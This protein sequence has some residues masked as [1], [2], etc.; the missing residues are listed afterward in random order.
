MQQNRAIR[1]GFTLAKH[2]RLKSR[3][4]LE[5]LFRQAPTFFVYPYK[6]YY[7]QDAGAQA[8]P[9]QAAF[10]VSARTFKK[11]ADRNRIKRLTREVYRLQKNPLQQKL[12]STGKKLAVFFLYTGKEVPEFDIVK[13]KM[14]AILAQLENKL[15][16]Q[17][18][19]IDK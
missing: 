11:A 15:P 12:A 2:E 6:V 10:G 9:L 7:Q 19:Q 18:E 16:A 1:Q 8:E 4:L 5:Q 17:R 3:K 13:E 14:Q